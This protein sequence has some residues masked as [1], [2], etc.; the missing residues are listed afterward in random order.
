MCHDKAALPRAM[1]YTHSHL[2]VTNQQHGYDASLLHDIPQQQASMA[3]APSACCWGTRF[4]RARS[5]EK[6]PSTNQLLI[7]SADRR[8]QGSQ[9]GERYARARKVNCCMIKNRS[10]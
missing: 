4:Q 5:K 2:G 10:Q 7:Q 6:G 3:S 9:D 1:L 8:L